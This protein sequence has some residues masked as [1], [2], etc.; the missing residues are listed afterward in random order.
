MQPCSMQ[1][2]QQTT[3]YTIYA[4]PSSLNA[5]K[6]FVMMEEC[7]HVHCNLIH[8][9]GWLAPGANVYS[10]HAGETFDNKTWDAVVDSKAYRD[11]NPNPTG[12]RTTRDTIL[13]FICEMYNRAVALCAATENVVAVVV[14]V[15]ATVTLSLSANDASP[16]RSGRRRALREQRDCAVSRAETR[17][18]A[19]RRL[20]LGGG[21]SAR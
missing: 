2:T 8:A 21:R 1:P 13:V 3:T 7:E 10:H 9:S 14:V 6:V 11:M 19:S 15:V 18:G 12:T 4:R 16:K 5:I 20:G 17:A